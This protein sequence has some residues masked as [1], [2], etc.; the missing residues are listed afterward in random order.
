M[1]SRTIRSNIS[2]SMKLPALITL[3]LVMSLLPSVSVDAQRFSA[4]VVD[5][6]THE[7]LPFASVYVNGKTSTITNMEGA[8]AIKCDSADMLRIS[9]VGYKTAFIHASQM[10]N[11]VRLT[12]N[13][14]LLHEVVVVPIAPMINKIAKET[15]RMIRKNSH[16]KSEFFYRQTAFSDSTCYEFAESFLTGCP[17]VTLNNLR[18]LTGRYAGLQSD[19][20][21]F[22][23]YFGNFY[24]FSQVEVAA[25]YA[26]PKPSNDIVPLFRNYD[27]YYDVDYYVI[28]ENDSR[29]FVIRFEPKPESQQKYAIVAATLYVDEQTLHL[30]RIVGE[31]RNFWIMTRRK[32]EVDIPYI[33]K[34][35][36][37]IRNKIC[38]TVRFDVHLNDTRGFPEV[39]SVFVEETHPERGID[40]LSNPK[41][42][43]TRSLLYNL[44]IEGAEK[45]KKRNLFQRI[46]DFFKE[47]VQKENRS[48]SLNFNNRLHDKIESQGYDPEF[49]DRNEIVRRTPIEQEVL[50]LFQQKNLFGL[51]NP[52]E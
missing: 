39:Q 44:S 50:E 37:Y 5:A 6:N 21:N 52:E 23:H 32:V 41:T 47:Q 16:R 29:M 1:T 24:T 48:Q 33:G 17:A 31:G 11:V 51:M 36:K 34:V 9:Y 13:E 40:S 20:L 4:T 35:D 19:S 43:T 18:L 10:G 49:W 3:L 42:V 14:T 2:F 28:T 38:T 30:R 8:F 26:Y 15:L 27:K 12:P 25:N 46:G 7:I 22:Y 45:Q